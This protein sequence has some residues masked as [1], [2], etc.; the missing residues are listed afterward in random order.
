MDES[1]VQLREEEKDKEKDNEKAVRELLES[2]Q[3][4]SVH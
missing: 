4:D 1:G 3:T 2:V